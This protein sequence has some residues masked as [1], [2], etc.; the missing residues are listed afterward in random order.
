MMPKSR[1]YEQELIEYLQDPEW[2]VAYLNAALE[3]G[4]EE[5]FLVALQNVVKASGK[6]AD[7]FEQLEN[8]CNCRFIGV[9]QKTSPWL[10]YAKPVPLLSKERD[11]RQDRVRFSRTFG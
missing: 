4:E 6:E 8:E 9:A 3:E 1:S 5:L 11:V 10:C 7:W 2:A